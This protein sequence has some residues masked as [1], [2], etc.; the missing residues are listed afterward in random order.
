MAKTGSLLA[1]LA[2]GLL[3]GT[4]LAGAALAQQQTAQVKDMAAD[5]FQWLE[6]VEGDKAIAWAREQNAKTLARLEKDPRF[7]P[8]RAEAERILTAR[9]RIPYGSLEGGVVDNFWQDEN[10]VRGLWRRTTVDSYRTADPAWDVVLDIDALAREENEN[11]VYQGH[12]CLAPDSSRCLVRLS[13]GGKDAAV[14]REFDVEKKAFVKGG[15]VLFEAKQWYAWADQDTLLV[16]S[17][18]GPDSMTDSGYP[19]QVRLWKRGT[20][21]TKAPVLLTV[22]KDDVWARPL[23]IHRPEGTVLLLNRGPDFFTEEW[24][25][26]GKDGK[27]TKLALP[28]TVELQGTF[29]GR[30]LLL[31]RAAWTVGGKTLPQGALVAVPLAEIEGGAA[32][33]TAELILAPT[34][35]VAIQSVAIAKDAVY[36]ALLDDVK[37]RLTALTPGKD[38]WV[39]KDVALPEAGSLRIVSTDSFSTDVLVNFASFLQPDTLYLMPG[40]GAPEAIKSLPARFDAA[41]FTTEQRFATSADGTRVPYFIVKRKGLEPT[42]DAPTLMY[43]YGGFEISSTPSYLSPL[44]KAW[45]EAGGVYAV[46]NIRGG[47]EYGPRWHQ[48]ALKENRQRAFDDFAAVAEDLVKTKVTSPKRLGIFGGSNGGL[49]VGTAFTQ[50]PDLYS[51]VICAVPL[52]DMLRYNKLLAGASWMGEYGNPDIPEE[53]AYIEKYSPYQNVKKDKDYPEVFFYTSTKDDRVHPGHAR[54]MAARMQA[55][56]HPVLYYE[57]I[58]GGHSAAANLKQRAFITGLQGVYLMQKLMAPPKDR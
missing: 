15:F 36:A 27:T 24:H 16:A 45:L 28:L 8:L 18:F 43:G 44:S 7:E 35:T 17:D 20:E 32:P 29:Q 2:A 13:R 23:A 34:D 39:R 52:L 57:N 26:V 55:Q 1:A 41:P 37:G 33:K 31:L 48:A 12:L 14:I 11:W 3:A 56:G 46:A 25:L 53:R 49:L 21:L 6:E 40:G 5:E 9:D 19:R 58:E 54:K 47:G 22:A 51:A 30:L 4:G 42:G 10:H 50:R 38:G